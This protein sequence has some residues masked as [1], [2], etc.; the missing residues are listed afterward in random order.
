MQSKK[1][2]VGEYFGNL[3]SGRSGGLAP[4]SLEKWLWTFIGCILG[5]GIITFLACF[6]GNPLLA[7]PLSMSACFIYADPTGSIA[8]PRRAFLG[9]LIAAIMGLA[10]YRLLGATW[11]AESLSLGLVIAAMMLTD[12]MHPPAVATVSLPFFT[13][14]GLL[15]PLLISIGVII[16]LI[17]AFF[18]NHLA[19]RQYPRFWW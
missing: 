13:E 9:N 18:V 7:A 2:S 17:V 6:I 19:R 3:I 16:L 8:Q 14:Q 11:Y 5:I 12:S 1:A 4:P 15:F 10:F